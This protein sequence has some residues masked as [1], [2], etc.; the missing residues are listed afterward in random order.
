[1]GVKIFDEVNRLPEGVIAA[2]AGLQRTADGK[3]WGCP[4]GHG[5]GIRQEPYRGKLSWHCYSAYHEGNQHMS[6]CDLIAAAHGIKDNAELARWLEAKFPET[7]SATSFF[8]EGKNSTEEPARRS[9][10]VE[11]AERKNHTRLYERCR[12][13]L[14]PFLGSIGG[15][16]RGLTIETL[17]GAQAGYNSRFHSMIFP[18]D[19][20]SF[21]WRDIEGTR[22]GFSKG[23]KRRLYYPSPVA[24]IKTGAGTVNFLT[25]GE[26][27]ALSVKQALSGHLGWIGVAAAGSLGFADKTIRELNTIFGN[28]S[29]KPKFIFL[30]DNDADERKRKAADEFVSKLNAAGYPAILVFFS[31]DC[32]RKVDANQFLQDYGDEALKDKLLSFVADSEQE[33]E[34]RS[35]E[36]QRKAAL[37]MGIKSFS[38]SEYL[39]KG[40]DEELARNE[41]YSG[42]ATG[43]EN[44][45]EVQHFLPGLYGLGG[46][47]GA[48]KTTFALQLLAQLAEGNQL[49]FR[50]PELCHFCSYEMSAFELASRLIAREMRRMKLANKGE[51]L[52]LS[53]ADIR[54]GNGHDSAEFRR[55]KQKVLATLK[56]L[57][58][59]E[60][61][62]T[63][64]DKLISFLKGQ[65]QSAA[66]K[67]VTIAIDY[68]QLIPVDNSKATAK[69][70]IDE[71]V[72]E[73]KPFQRATG[74]TVILIS[75]VNRDACISGVKNMFVYKESGNI[76]YSL[77]V[78]WVLSCEE[79]K[80]KELPRPVTL[81]CAKNR[82]GAT[83]EASFEYWA[84]SDYFCPRRTAPAPKDDNQRKPKSNRNC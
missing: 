61:E 70:R 35:E 13:A 46:V 49:E 7:K 27:D 73:L 9:E 67:P 4:C 48:G 47:P 44:L 63:P 43:F 71:I 20:S 23:G 3:R 29:N 57:H 39:A 37:A 41:K 34:R 38:L 17:H 1:M 12:A 26:I 45:D 82:N 74:T 19:E 78:A 5:D 28:S 51:G 59:V 24:Q 80:E 50:E 33:L 60:L 21:F 79:G 15:K 54:R 30:G 31:D 69:E 65:V 22:R 66:G 8:L 36:I 10:S 25:E 52:A 83:Y 18:Y 14:S 77:D 81:Y 68:L 56:N 64:I 2:A 53:S 40:F 75:S 58:I 32:S 72:R 62:N 76:E 84:Q 42:R 6:N 55:A 11:A 16:W